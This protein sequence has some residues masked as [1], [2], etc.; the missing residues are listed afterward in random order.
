MIDICETKL[1]APEHR[2]CSMNYLIYKQLGRDDG[3]ETADT[4]RNTALPQPDL[5]LVKQSL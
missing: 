2:I 3:T 4:A 5:E 1:N